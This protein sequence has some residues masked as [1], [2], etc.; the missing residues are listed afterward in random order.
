[1]QG[2]DNID[3]ACHVSSHPSNTTPLYA[4]INNVIISDNM[5]S[6]LCSAQ[7]IQGHNRTTAIDCLLFRKRCPAEQDIGV[8]I[9]INS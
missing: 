3:I 6:C 2:Y 4:A 9:V 8:P 1:M 5:V 7:N